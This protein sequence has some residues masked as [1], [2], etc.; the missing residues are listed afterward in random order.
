MAAPAVKKW[1]LD[2]SSEGCTGL[3]YRRRMD[4]GGFITDGD[5]NWPRNGFV[6]SGVEAAPGFVQLVDNPNKWLPISG[7]GHTYLHEVK[8]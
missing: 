1:R 4:D 5:P 8:E 2:A 6:F 3:Y 7:H